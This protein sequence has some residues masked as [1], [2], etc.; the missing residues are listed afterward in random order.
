MD[1]LDIGN[2]ISLSIMDE[3]DDF[4][5]TSSGLFYCVGAISLKQ[6]MIFNSMCN[7]FTCRQT[8]AAVSPF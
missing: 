6:T 5:Q 8:N 3:G 2:G 1:E 7:E 4:S